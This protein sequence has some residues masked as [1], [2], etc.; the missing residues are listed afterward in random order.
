M[1][2]ERRKEIA[3]RFKEKHL[4]D[5]MASLGDAIEALTEEEDYQYL[6]IATSA[7]REMI[8]DKLQTICMHTLATPCADNQFNPRCTKCWYRQA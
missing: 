8:R 3:Q 4:L 6:W 2:P 5:A 7:T 1:T